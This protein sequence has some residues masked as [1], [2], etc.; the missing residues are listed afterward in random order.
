M[1]EER[2]VDKASE[3]RVKEFLDLIEE[4]EYDRARVLIDG[5]LLEYPECAE[6]YLGLLL[7]EM[8]LR[9]FDDFCVTQLP[10]PTNENFRRLL[11]YAEGELKEDLEGIIK[12]DEDIL[13]LNRIELTD[14]GDYYEVTQCKSEF[15]YITIPASYK[16]KIIKKIGF[17]AFDKNIYTETVILPPTVTDIDGIA[18]RNCTNLYDISIPDSVNDI[19]TYAFFGCSRLKKIVIPD[20]VKMLGVYVFADCHSLVDVELPNNLDIITAGFFFG[21]RSL[22]KINLPESLTEI[23]KLA[24]AG[25]KALEA[26][27]LPKKISIIEESAFLDCK[28]LIFV[29]IPRDITEIHHTAFEKCENAVIFYE[30]SKEEFEKIVTK[31]TVTDSNIYLYSGNGRLMASKEREI[32]VYFYSEKKKLFG[33]NLW[34]YVDGKPWIW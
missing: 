8:E 22:K 27:Y 24:F 12:A 32:P 30:G 33:K 25:C 21:C 26:I 34:R 28:S 6:A 15:P 7:I 31:K 2:K 3:E 23:R 11:M 9:S 16:G 5:V 10:P 13:E 17:G 20:S 14:L 19:A 18:F 1:I 29:L 4:G